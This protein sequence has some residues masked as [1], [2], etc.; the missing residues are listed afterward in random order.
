LAL[1]AAW[2][3]L[4]KRAKFAALIEL[5][6]VTVMPSEFYLLAWVHMK[7]F[8]LGKNVGCVAKFALPQIVSPILMMPIFVA[9]RAQ[10]LQQQR[11]CNAL[12]K[13]SV[14]KFRIT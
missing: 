6:F 14:H 8:W 12:W 7:V 2:E 4:R 1:R 11:E 10:Q 9:L 3:L 5:L 13:F